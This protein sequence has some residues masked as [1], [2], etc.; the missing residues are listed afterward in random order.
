MEP[1]AA[2]FRA[3]DTVCQANAKGLAGRSMRVTAFR[4]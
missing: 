4:F 3:G 2:A 1:H